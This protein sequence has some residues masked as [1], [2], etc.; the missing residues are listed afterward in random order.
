VGDLPNSPIVPGTLVIAAAGGGVANA[1][2]IYGDG[3]LYLIDDLTLCG[4]IDYEDG[5]LNLT[6]PTGHAPAAGNLTYSFQGGTWLTAYGNRVIEVST[7]LRDDLVRIRGLA[8]KT[9]LAAAR[10]ALDINFGW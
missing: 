7:P 2:D 6:Y 3:N 5:Y 8:K 4:T 1:Q 10:V 9:G